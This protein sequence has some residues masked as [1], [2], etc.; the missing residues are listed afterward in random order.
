MPESAVPAWRIDLFVVQPGQQ[1][2]AVERKMA[3]G[4]IESRKIAAHQVAVYE[5]ETGPVRRVHLNDVTDPNLLILPEA[6]HRIAQPVVR[7][8]DLDDQE[9]RIQHNAIGL[10]ERSSH[11]DDIGYAIPIKSGASSTTRSVWRNGRPM[12]TI[13]GTR[14][15][16]SSIRVRHSGRTA[17]LSCFSK[18]ARCTTSIF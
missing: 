1:I 13:S 15:R 5:P 14:Y 2:A 10:A 16:V 8:D 7:R 17:I 11:D 3:A 18:P 6:L 4:K 9:R 12:T